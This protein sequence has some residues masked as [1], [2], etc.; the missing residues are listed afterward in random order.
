MPHT[1]VA[2]RAGSAAYA[3][4]SGVDLHHAMSSPPGCSVGESPGAPGSSPNPSTAAR[5]PPQRVPSAP[6][7]LTPLARGLSCLLRAPG[8]GLG[9]GL[10]Q[11]PAA[12]GTG[13]SPGFHAGLDA[14]RASQGGASECSSC[15]PAPAGERDSSFAAGYAHKARRQ[16]PVRILSHL[17]TAQRRGLP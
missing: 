14:P 16:Y 17:A 9:S 1:P 3:H 15:G 7:E 5:Q 11:E 4:G 12:G 2:R 8:S 6:G 10:G 13:P